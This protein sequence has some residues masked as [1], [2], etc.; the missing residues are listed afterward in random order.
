MRTRWAVVLLAAGCTP[1]DAGQSREIA[2]LRGPHANEV[3]GVAFSRD[4]SRL[5]TADNGGVLVVWD[6]TTR[7]STIC[8]TPATP[9]RSPS[10][11]TASG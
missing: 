3:E 1:L 9:K 8:A 7:L 2:V 6:A 11:R 4:G 5:V 10:L